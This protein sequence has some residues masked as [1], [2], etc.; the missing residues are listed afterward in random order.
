MNRG[1]VGVTL[2]LFGVSGCIGATSPTVALQSPQVEAA[3]VVFP[4]TWV[5][6][7]VDSR[8]GVQEAVVQGLEEHALRP[9]LRAERVMEGLHVASAECAENLECV[10]RVGRDIGAE[11]VVLLQL[12]ELGDTAVLRLTIINAQS[13]SEEGSSQQVVEGGGRTA[14]LEAAHN[15]GSTVSAGFLPRRPWY[16]RWW[17]WTLLA[18]TA[19]GVTGVVLATQPEPLPDASGVIRTPLLGGIW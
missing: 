7:G 1:L 6:G 11:R 5:A 16:A 10:C 8:A 14:L 12:A 18:V 17:P 13:E 19:A 15:L 4:E 3:F 2:V 9:V